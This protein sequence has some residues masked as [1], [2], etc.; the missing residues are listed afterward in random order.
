[1][2]QEMMAL[3]ARGII[4]F[5]SGDSGYQ[6]NQQYGSSCPYVTS[7]GGVWNGEG[8]DRSKTALF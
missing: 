3:G 7:V 5:A 1:M 4:I 8:T 2:N 6:V